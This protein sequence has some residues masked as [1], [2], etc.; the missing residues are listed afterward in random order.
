MPEPVL[1]KCYIGEGGIQLGKYLGF[2]DI[3][4]AYAHYAFEYGS[5]RDYDEKKAKLVEIPCEDVIAPPPPPPPQPAERYPNIPPDIGL[6]MARDA[7]YTKIALFILENRIEEFRMGVNEGNIEGISIYTISSSY[8]DSFSK[9][10]VPYAK[11]GNPA[12][13]VEE[14]REALETITIKQREALWQSLMNGSL[15]SEEDKSI[16]TPNQEAQLEYSHTEKQ[17]HRQA[18]GQYEYIKYF[19]LKK[20]KP[21][22]AGI[23]GKN[24]FSDLNLKN[25]LETKR[26]EQLEKNTKD[27]IDER[28]LSQVPFK[29]LLEKLENIRK[30]KEVLVNKTRGVENG[31]ASFGGGK[32]MHKIRHKNTHKIRRKKRQ[33][34]TRN[35]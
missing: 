10:L 31:R 32:N 24:D 35:K 28:I 3:P 18:F 19:K 1:G 4:Q 34:K 6:Q 2:N 12:L 23:P 5:V 8:M 14:W 30:S 15:V 17:K 27:E 9:D 13:N 11:R 7:N 21:Y 29:N 25:L 33:R 26:L 16:L 22:I 20:P